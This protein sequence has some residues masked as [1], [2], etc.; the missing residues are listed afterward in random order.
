MKRLLRCIAL[1]A[2]AAGL[3]AC[4]PP[5]K[6]VFPPTITIQQMEVRPNGLWHLVLRIQNNSYTGMTFHSI[7]GTLQVAD[8]IPVRLHADFKRDIPALSGD[9]TT[10]DILPTPAMAK[11]LA[12]VAAKGS[13]GS[14]A[15]RISG[16]TNATPEREKETKEKPRDFDF[17]GNDWL[18]PVPGIPNTYR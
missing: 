14:L 17:H 1:V 5:R 7:D 8:D 16:S 12:A 15:Y 2:L 11:A 18:S 6:S 4:G 3:A 10:L 13:A 9:V